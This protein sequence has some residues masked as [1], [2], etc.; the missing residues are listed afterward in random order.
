MKVVLIGSGSVATHLGLALQAKGVIISQ[1]YSRNIKNAETLSEKLN[2]SFITDIS[3]IYK[4]ADIYFYALTDNAFKSILRKIEM[5]EGIQVH[6]AGCI[7]MGEFEGFTTKF[8][9]LYPLQTF[10]KDKQVDFSQIPICI[11]A[12]D[13]EVQKKLLEIG[14]LLSNKTY[15]INSEQR[16]KI[17]LAAVFACNFTNYMYDVASK[18][19]EDSG[20]LFEIIQPLIAETAEKIKTMNPY[21][22]Q[23]GPA[24]RMDKKTISKHLSMLNK[25]PDL[26]KIYKIL[27][28]NIYIR[29]KKQ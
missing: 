17:H 27:T 23:T 4:D 8:G 11:E 5:P 10:S 13:L 15:I 21:E 25:R 20:F 26:K 7:P 12:S 19:L 6:T 9:V 1:V 22:A 14:N 28:K 3:D 2:T 18:I 24:V 29:H 16:K